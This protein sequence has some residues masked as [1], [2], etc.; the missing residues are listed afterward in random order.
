VYSPLLARPAVLRSW[1]READLLAMFFF[2]TVTWDFIW[3]ACNWHFG[4]ARFRKG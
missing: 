3:F 4:V 2:L 1:E